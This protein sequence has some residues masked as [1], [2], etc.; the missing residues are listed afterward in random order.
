MGL[1]NIKDNVVNFGKKIIEFF[2]EIS[3]L[4]F[5]HTN[6]QIEEK[7][8]SI[9]A[10]EGGGIANPTPHGISNPTILVDW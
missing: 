8:K 4:T 7:K 3:Y 1:V 2:Y 9:W 6:I 5:N 10:H